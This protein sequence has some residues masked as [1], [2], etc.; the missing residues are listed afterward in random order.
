MIEIQNVTPDD[1][2]ALL[3]IYAPYVEKTAISFEYDVPTLNEFRERIINTLKKYPYIKAVNESGKI[4]GYAYAGAFKTRRAYDKSC[5]ASI[6]VDKNSHGS[7][8]GRALY[9]SL[10]AELKS[11]GFMNIYACV[12][13][14]EVEDE[15]LTH[16]SLKFHEH[17]GFKPVG[18]FNECACKFGR[19]YSMICLEKF[20]APHV[21]INSGDE[22]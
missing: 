14:P 17:M 13:Y 19:F 18:K 1:A 15:Y 6:Y 20:I 11:R 9:D 10:E 12:A 16:N 5:E 8:I 2:E 7:G 3:E 4:L 22:M 21:I